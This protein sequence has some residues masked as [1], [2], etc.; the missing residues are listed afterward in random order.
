M[1]TAI[2]YSLSD[3]RDGMIKYVGKTVDAK[4]RFK[5][6]LWKNKN[7]RTQKNFWI[8][9]LLKNNLQPQLEI[10]DEVPEQEWQ[11]WEQYWIAQMKEWGF[12]LKNGDNGGLGFD[13]FNEAVKSKISK[14]LTGRSTG[15]FIAYLKYDLYGSFIEKYASLKLAKIVLGLSEFNSNIPTAF[16]RHGSAYGF[17]WIKEGTDANAWFNEYKLK[18]E[19][20][21]ERNVKQATGLSQKYLK[22]RIPSAETKAKQSL[23]KIGK[24]TWN[25]GLVGVQTA[26]NKGIKGSTR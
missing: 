24:P 18:L 20:A 2:I 6:H 15:K 8:Q 16:K 17:I 1:K 12:D 22:G 26:W 10:I 25:K 13:R 23:A 5:S 9:Y 7:D 14:T 21:H 19:R 4:Y 3:P 11:F